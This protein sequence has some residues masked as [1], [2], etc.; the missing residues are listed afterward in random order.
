MQRPGPE[1]RASRLF[2]WKNI[3]LI[4]NQLTFQPN[5]K[6]VQALVE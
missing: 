2:L 6:Q 5:L 3:T 1:I 4:A